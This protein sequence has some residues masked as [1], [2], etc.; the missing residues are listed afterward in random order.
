MEITTTRLEEVTKGL[1][2]LSSSRREEIRKAIQVISTVT[3]EEWQILYFGATGLPKSNIIV[4]SDK[5]IISQLLKNLGI[6]ANLKGYQYLLLAIVTYKQKPNISLSK[7]LYPQI[8]QEYNTTPSRVERAIRHAI[9]IGF[10][11][12]DRSLYKKIFENSI[13]IEKSRPTNGEFIA[14]VAEWLDI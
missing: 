9:E 7:K 11:R 3:E 13:S 14:C 1:K 4:R 10:T 12:G 6:P 8:A 5:K 2:G